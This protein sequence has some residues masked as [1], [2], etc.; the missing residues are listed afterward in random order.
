M[1]ICICVCVCVYVCVHVIHLCSAVS[2]ARE[3]NI[4]YL[5]NYLYILYS[6][7]PPLVGF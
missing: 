1:S 3:A 6:A 7:P 5:V 2:I 4:F